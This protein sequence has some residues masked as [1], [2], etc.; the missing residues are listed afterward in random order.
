MPFC[1]QLTLLHGCALGE[2]S[3]GGIWK[4]RT[5]SF[6]CY[7][8]HSH[9]V[10]SSGN[11]GIRNWVH[12]FESFCISAVRNCGYFSGCHFGTS[13]YWSILVSRILYWHYV[14]VLCLPK[15]LVNAFRKVWVHI[16]WGSITCLTVVLY[17]IRI[18]HVVLPG[19][20]AWDVVCVK[21]LCSVFTNLN[22]CRH[23]AR[24]HND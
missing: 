23:A 20:F 9:T 10:Y 8:D 19:N 3:S 1:S 22:T 21:A 15:T 5:S 16:L 4:F 18:W 11:I 13:R 12:L 2:R 6:K 7:V 14:Y 24:R 17:S